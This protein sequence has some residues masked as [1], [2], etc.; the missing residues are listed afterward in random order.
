MFRRQRK[1]GINVTYMTSAGT[2]PT[3][4]TACH[5]YNK[6]INHEKLIDVK[7]CG[8][9]QCKSMKDFKKKHP[10]PKDMSYVKG[11]IRNMEK[12]DLSVVLKL[13]NIQ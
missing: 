12:K 9:G 3:P 6:Y 4:F 8:L 1:N 10:I 5:Y 2:F 13:H 11:Q 7:Y